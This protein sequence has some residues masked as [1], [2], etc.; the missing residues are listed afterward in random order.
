MVRGCKF[1]FQGVQN[2][3]IYFLILYVGSEFEYFYCYVNKLKPNRPNTINFLEN[4]FK[5]WA[6]VR[7]ATT[8]HDRK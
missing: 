6:L 1:V 8:G 5:I 7:I 2:I 4:G 3:Y